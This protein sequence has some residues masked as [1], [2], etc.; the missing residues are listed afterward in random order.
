[1]V[2]ILTHYF[3]SEQLIKYTL[4]ALQAQAFIT[5]M[6]VQ[7]LEWH[8]IINMIKFQSERHISAL[9]VDKQDFNTKERKVSLMVSLAIALFALYHF[10]KI[11]IALALLA[12]CSSSSSRSCKIKKTDVY[13]GLLYSD[14]AVIIVTF[15]YFFYVIINVQRQAYLRFRYEYYTHQTYFIIFSMGM[16]LCMPLVLLEMVYWQIS[17]EKYEETRWIYYVSFLAHSIPTVI[18]IYAKPNEDCFNC[19]NRVTHLRYSINQYTMQDLLG[20]W[21]EREEQADIMRLHVQ[22]HIGDTMISSRSSGQVRGTL[23]R[24]LTRFSENSTNSLVFQT[25]PLGHTYTRM[26]ECSA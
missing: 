24:P 17:Y 4:T 20:L 13:N 8:L 16:F 26:S 2:I 19:F 22:P 6:F 12:F 21:I 9:D 3:K 14:I 23:S 1:M 7:L 25:L 11:V 18:C 15:A 10:L 5:A